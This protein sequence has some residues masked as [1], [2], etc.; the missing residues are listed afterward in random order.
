[1]NRAII[2]LLMLFLSCGCIVVQ[3][4]ATRLDEETGSLHVDL[5]SDTDGKESDSDESGKDG[6]DSEIAEMREKISELER[7]IEQAET[8]MEIAEMERELAEE[9][10]EH[11]HREGERELSDAERDLELFH[12]FGRPEMTHG[13][14]RGLAFAESSFLDAK[15]ELE[16]LTILYEG[17]ELEDGTDELVLERGRRGLERAQKAL[18]QQRRD[19]RHAMEIEIPTKERDLQR[20]V[21]EARRDLER[22]ELESTIAELR[23]ELEQGERDQELD[24]MREE[25]EEMRHDLRE[26]TG[27]RSQSTPVAWRVF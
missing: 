20:A 16:Q 10:R 3:S 27:D 23:A 15:A 25:L 13:A 9:A 24:E 22:G 4:D 7:K 21:A 11:R 18:E 17:S 26:L 12:Q 6:K 19:H 1:M 14:Q 5:R 2:T 8:R